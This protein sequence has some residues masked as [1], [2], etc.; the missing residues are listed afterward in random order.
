MKS[1]P[2]FE[3]KRQFCDHV[4]GSLQIIIYIQENTKMIYSKE[5]IAAKIKKE[6]EA[7]HV[8]SSLR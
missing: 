6:L 1:L 4:P 2:Y 3:K 7:V 8:V 5:D